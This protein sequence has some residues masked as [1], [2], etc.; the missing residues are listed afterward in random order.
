MMV[1]TYCEYP[2]DNS[3]PFGRISSICP[4]ATFPPPLASRR[5][6]AP[7]LSLEEVHCVR[8]LQRLCQRRYRL[9][10]DVCV[11]GIFGD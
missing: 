3:S 1:K 8:G 11:D 4:L 7:L 5:T 9:R 6:I 2:C 10:G